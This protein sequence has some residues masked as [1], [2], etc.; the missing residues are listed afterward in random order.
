MDKEETTSNR[1]SNDEISRSNS[2]PNDL[3]VCKKKYV[4]KLTIN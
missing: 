3:V 4:F 1:I 2:I